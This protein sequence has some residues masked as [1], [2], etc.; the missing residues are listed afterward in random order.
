MREYQTAVTSK[1]QATVPSEV[2]RLLGLKPHD[3]LAFIVEDGGVRIERARSV[4][5]RTA[6]LLR[7]DGPP[8]SAEGLRDLAERAIADDVRDRTRE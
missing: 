3:K 6:G 1:G 4:V 5:E 7:S 2:R 8:L